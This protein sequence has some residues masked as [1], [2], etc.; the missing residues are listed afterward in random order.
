MTAGAAVPGRPRGALLSPFV[1]ALGADF[2]RLAPAVRRHL[3]QPAGASRLVGSVRRSWRRGGPLGWL[4]GRILRLGFDANV[5]FELRNELRNEPAG[6][7]MVWRRALPGG[8]GDQIGVMRW[9]PRRGAL[10]DTVGTRRRIE[11]ELVPGVED[12]ALALVSRGQRLRIFG[13]AV[14]LPR[15]IA[16]SARV[17]EREEPGERIVLSLAVSHPWLG[18]Y[19]GY[20]AELR[21]AR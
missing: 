16:G 1:A 18:E 5:R 3:A 15:A 17:R 21:E 4:L 12:G 6:T 7:A 10:V 2:D 13:L 20:E 19:A 14:P 9:D 8:R 11:V